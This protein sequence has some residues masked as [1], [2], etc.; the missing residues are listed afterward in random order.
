MTLG[1]YPLLL[2][3]AVSLLTLCELTAQPLE[4]LGI[5]RLRGF[6]VSPEI[7]EQDVEE[8]S[9]WKGNVI[10]YHLQW[11]SVADSANRAQYLEWL[12]G[13]LEKLDSLVE[14]CRTRKI[15]VVVNIHTPP[16]GFKSA[17]YPSLHRMFVEHWALDTFYETW[18]RIALRYRGDDTVWGFD[19]LNEPALRSTQIAIDSWE[20]IARNTASIINEIDPTR[21]II[22]EP[23][24]G[25]QARMWSIRKLDFPTLVV[26]I[27]Y[28]YP[29]RFHHQGIYG[30]PLGV[31]YPLRSFN[32][33]SLLKNLRTVMRYQRSTKGKIRIYVGEFTANRWAPGQSAHR[34]LRDF[35]KIMER[36]RWD[37]TY[38]SFREADPWNLEVEG[39]FGT[40]RK[41]IG[42]TNRERLIKQFLV[43]NRP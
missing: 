34:Y 4:A 37:W 27:H 10:R 30:N 6:T 25:D 5:G 20:V 3:L 42:E 24:Y 18:K 23:L 11:T 7:T 16:G 26:S 15:K 12:E 33:S 38:H 40:I 8:I 2:A 35:I 14:W 22:V 13:A 21:L 29:L 19:I 36:Q 32:R 17:D 28:Y 39:V 41:V 1:L 31:A 43:R 9:A